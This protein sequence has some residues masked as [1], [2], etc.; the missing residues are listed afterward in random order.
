MRAAASIGPELRSLAFLGW[1]RSLFPGPLQQGPM[2]KTSSPDRG[3]GLFL[4]FLV[5]CSAH[6]RPRLGALS[7]WCGKA[8]R[9]RASFERFCWLS[10]HLLSLWVRSPPP[11]SLPAPWA[12][13]IHAIEAP[14]PIEHDQP[15]PPTQSVVPLMQAY[16]ALSERHHWIRIKCQPSS[17]PWPASLAAS[18]VS[19]KSEILRVGLM[20]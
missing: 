6:G 12:A 16:E 19:P 10:P 20:N 3:R 13:C 11:W 14:G 5:P 7:A 2:A 4:G 15:C 9:G 1:F 18:S 8:C 17:A